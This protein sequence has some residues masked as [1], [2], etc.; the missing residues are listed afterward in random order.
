[1][2]DFHGIARRTF[3]RHNPGPTWVCDFCSGVVVALNRRQG[4]VHHRDEDIS[5]ND[6]SNLGAMHPGC[7]EKHHIR[8]S[9]RQQASR[10]FIEA[11]AAAAKVKLAGMPRPAHVVEALQAGAR[12]FQADPERA[13]AAALKGWETRRR[14][15]AEKARR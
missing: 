9:G 4:L 15:A 1:M 6:P 5:N 14:K 12:A 11:G 7:H 2:T 3:R 10:A 8:T 13:R